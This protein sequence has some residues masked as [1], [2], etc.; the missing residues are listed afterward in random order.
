MKEVTVNISGLA[1]AGKS[2]VAFVIQEAL[3]DAGYNLDIVVDDKDQ[4]A[5]GNK[6]QEYF[7]YLQ[8]DKGS[9]KERAQQ[10]KV[11]IIETQLCR[12]L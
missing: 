2:T 8:S 9:L 10:T 1:G 3:K 12:E 7:S 5:S 6:V 11:R 4:F